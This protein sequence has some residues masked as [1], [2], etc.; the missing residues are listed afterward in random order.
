[1]GDLLFSQGTDRNDRHNNAYLLQL[2]AREFFCRDFGAIA[3][4]E[5]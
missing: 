5:A 4:Y 2:L 1:M 3:K